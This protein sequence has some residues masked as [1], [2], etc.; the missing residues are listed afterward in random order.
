MTTDAR[1]T[2]LDD[3]RLR[4]NNPYGVEAT[5]FASADVP[6][7]SAAVTELVDLLALQD[8]V[9]QVAAAEPD[10]FDLDPDIVRVAVTPDFH[11]AKG[12]PVGTVMATRG[13]VVPQAIGS[14]INCG[15]RLHTTTLTADAVAANVDALD[16]AFRHLFFEGGRDIPMTR[17][18][19][20]ALL[21]GG[22]D[23][24]LNATPADLTTGLW[25]LVRELDVGRSLDRVERRGS[26]PASKVFGLSDFMGPADRPS[27]DGQIGSI[28]G[29]NHFVEIQK[30]EKVLDRTV[31]HAWGLK[32]GVVT[33]MVHTGSVGIGHLCGGHYRDV[34]RKIY[35]GALKH[36]AN[37]VF[38]LPDG[39]RHRAH[40]N[41]FW[42]ALH[43]AA[44]FAFANRMF[45]A[46]M[47][48]AGFRRVLGDDV[49]FDLVY[50]APHNF[51]WK[52][53]VDGEAVA[54][55]RKGATPA[56]GFEAMAGTPFAYTGEP[57]LVPGSMGASSFVMVG[58]GNAE[59]MASASHGAGRILSRGDAMRGHDAEFEQFLRDF[60][61]VTPVD[62]RRPDV[63]RRPDILAK[64]LEELK[65]EAPFAY[66][67]VGP[68]VATLAAAGIARPVAELTPLMTVKG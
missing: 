15:M 17:N 25:G 56:R 62:L 27:R 10:S 29:G 24:L 8:T 3:T 49:G 35:P 59:S 45:L 20:Y 50:D 61:V 57:V 39:D 40:A 48:L 34:V 11:K 22:L 64:K 13:F 28:G 47:A 19:R 18:Q 58:Q 26:L 55:H 53:E 33:V 44:N 30:V 63:R 31:A 5:M 67:G 4:V 37:G 6:V 46:V 21:T 52:D 36:P 65:Q 2:R 12:I 16:T 32:P 43:N 23:G 66:K 1:L 54:V 68:V 41:L 60:R 7:E 14:D 38:V 42:D 51:I 9:R